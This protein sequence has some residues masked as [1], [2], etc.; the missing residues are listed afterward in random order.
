MVLIAKALVR[1]LAI[2][3]ASNG[4]PRKIEYFTI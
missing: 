4:F 3:E 2:E 1:R